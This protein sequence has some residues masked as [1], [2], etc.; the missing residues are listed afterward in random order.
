MVRSRDG[1]ATFSSTT[2]TC[3][4]VAAGAVCDAAAVDVRATAVFVLAM[5]VEVAFGVRVR[6]AVLA[7]VL[8]PAL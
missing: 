7:G 6:V 3:V 1:V 8:V 5:V 4:V 2:R